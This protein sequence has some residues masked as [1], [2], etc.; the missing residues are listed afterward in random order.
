MPKLKRLKISDIKL[1]DRNANRGTK[2][3]QEFIEGSL[4]KYGLG[5]SILLDKDGN[6]IAG[7]KTFEAFRAAGGK[8]IVVVGSKGD[9]LI[10]AQREDL[11]IGSRKGRSLAIADNRASEIDLDWHPEMLAS[12]DV[13]LSELF[14]DRDLRRIM[15]ALAPKIEAPEPRLDQAAQ[16]AAKWR[17]KPGQLWNIGPHRLYC[18]DC[19]Q[20][21]AWAAIMGGIR[22][23]MAFTDPPWNVAIGQDSNPRHRQR[24]GLQNDCLSAQDFQAF[25]S[26][27]AAHLAIHSAGDLYCV[28]GASEWPTLDLQLRNCGYHWSATIIWVKD[29][30][31]L[32]RSKYHRRYEPLWYGWHRKGKSSFTGARDVDDVWEIPRPRRSEE[33]PTMKPLELVARAIS[34]SSAVGGVACDP[35]LGSGTTMAA[36]QALGRVCYGMEIEPKYVAVAIERLSEM[37]LSPELASSTTQRAREE[38]GQKTPSNW[39]LNR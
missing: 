33:H 21:S 38:C 12:L 26:A 19:T 39:R 20:G 31:V 17:T 27:F 35:F 7:N 30:F 4:K 10:A 29:M 14:D 2:H 28:L 37:G 1:D 25:L 36:A 23:T 6:V 18:G 5:R 24:T 8:E 32:G 3:G 16:L 34:N 13:K 15:G 22:A 11:T 9:A